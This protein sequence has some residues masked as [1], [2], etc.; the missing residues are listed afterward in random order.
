MGVSPKGVSKGVGGWAVPSAF[1]FV[2]DVF[3]RVHLRGCHTRFMYGSSFRFSWDD[4]C[5]LHARMAFSGPPSLNLFIGKRLAWE[6]S[7]CT[8]GQKN[9]AK[10][11]LKILVLLFH[12]P[13]IKMVV[14]PRPFHCQNDREATTISR[15]CHPM[16]PETSAER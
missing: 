10:K 5:S 6:S 9:Q 14:K 11:P 1:P 7:T 4:S 3:L 15:S 13:A 16:V 12:H 2:K 8:V